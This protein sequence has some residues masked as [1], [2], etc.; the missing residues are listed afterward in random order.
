MPSNSLAYQV[1]LLLGVKALFFLAV[2]FWQ[3]IS[4][5][6]DQQCRTNRM[7]TPLCFDHQS[8]L[9]EIIASC[10]FNTVPREQ[11]A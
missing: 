6:L 11:P 5:F 4:D 3:S 10:H 1:Q 8:T 2:E 9:A 7:A